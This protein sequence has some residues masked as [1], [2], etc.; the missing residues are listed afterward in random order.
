MLL[1]VLAHLAMTHAGRPPA[2][3]DAV[4]ACLVLIT[5]GQAGSMARNGP[6]TRLT[7]AAEP[8]VVKE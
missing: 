2:G 4:L 1:L 6:R 8:A 5:A 7:V 3:Y